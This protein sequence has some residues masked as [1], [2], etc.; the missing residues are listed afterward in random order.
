MGISPISIVEEMAKEIRDK[1]DVVCN[2]YQSAE[3]VPDPRKLNSEKKSGMVFDDLLLKTQNTCES[4]YVTGRHSN[5]DCVYLD[6]NYFKLPHQTI[7]ENA[8]SICLFLQD[9]KNLNHIFDDHVGSDMTKEEFRQ[10]YKTAWENSK[11]L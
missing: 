7:R 8:N 6:Q 4:Y 3:D 11:G 9:L 5:V 1:S 2:F 10:L